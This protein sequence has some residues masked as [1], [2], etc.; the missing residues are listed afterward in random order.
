MNI[1][2]QTRV[3]TESYSP[4]CKY[5]RHV[6]HKVCEKC[7]PFRCVKG[8][9]SHIFHSPCSRICI[10]LIHDSFGWTLC[11]QACNGSLFLSLLLFCFCINSMV[12]TA[13]ERESGEEKVCC[14]LVV[15]MCWKV[16]VIGNFVGR[17]HCVY[18]E[19]FHFCLSNEVT[20]WPQ[21]NLEL[22]LHILDKTIWT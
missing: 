12:R 11:F 13:R 14:V 5:S 7:C 9:K 10:K 4:A 8:E 21:F 18:C 15:W 3:P 20:P 2:G 6:I 1:P 19:S 17:S 16:L 22:W